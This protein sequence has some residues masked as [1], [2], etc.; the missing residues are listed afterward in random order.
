MFWVILGS[1]CI[2][3]HLPFL[4]WTL[5]ASKSNYLTFTVCMHM[6][7]HMCTYAHAHAHTHTHSEIRGSED[8]HSSSAISDIRSGDG[9][10][11]WGCEHSMRRQQFFLC[12]KLSD[13]HSPLL[14]MIIWIYNWTQDSANLL[15]SSGTQEE[16]PC[17]SPPWNL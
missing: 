3:F 12:K 4:I 9:P 11:S 17:I 2:L 16:L 5:W 6:Y 15:P 13:P 14:S 10:Q 7:K 1:F 8:S